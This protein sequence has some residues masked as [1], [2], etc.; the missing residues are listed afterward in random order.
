M[1]AA[2]VFYIA[3]FFLVTDVPLWEAIL[4]DVV[5]MLVNL[6]MIGIVVRERSTR[7]M[8]RAE[9]ALY[10]HFPRMSPGHFRKLMSRA[11]RVTVAAPETATLE[12]APLDRLYFVLSG[13]V[14]VRKAGST[15]HL[16]ADGTFIGEVAFIAQVPASATVVFVPGTEYLVWPAAELRTLTRRQPA[17]GNALTAHLSEDMARKVAASRPVAP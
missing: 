2:S 17:L 1:L 7:A 3:Y 9:I 14:E 6:V 12:G 8:S 4:A 15:V 5:L 10:R 11:R 13:Q 16:P